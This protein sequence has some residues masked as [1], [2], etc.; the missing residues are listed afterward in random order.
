[1]SS[2]PNARELRRK[3][4]ETRGEAATFT[5]LELRASMTE[6]AAEYERLAGRAEDFEERAR[7]GVANPHALERWLK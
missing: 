1:M 7:L 2:I 4:E 3:A 5:I 6:V